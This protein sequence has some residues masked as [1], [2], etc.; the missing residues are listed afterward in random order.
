MPTLSVKPPTEEH[1]CFLRLNLLFQL[2][3]ECNIC[4]EYVLP[5][6]HMI[7]MINVIDA[8]S[9]TYIIT[10]TYTEVSLLSEH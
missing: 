7:I 9:T 2:F 10:Q 8:H 4:N 3:K 6:E 1:L 5:L